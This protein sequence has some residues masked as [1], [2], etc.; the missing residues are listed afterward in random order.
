MDTAPEQ[1]HR[2]AEPQPAAAGPEGTGDPAPQTEGSEDGTATLRDVIA[3]AYPDAVPEMISGET[4][5]E[6]LASVPT[7]REAYRQ[8]AETVRAGQPDPVPAGGGVRTPD[9]NL[10]AMSPELKIREALRRK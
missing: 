6:M 3:R 8:V 9:A 4:V 5:D 1:E 10:D 2:D 7:A